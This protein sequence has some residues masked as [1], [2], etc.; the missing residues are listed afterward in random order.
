MFAAAAAVW[1]VA[2][3]EIPV[4]WN[5]SGEVD[6]YGGKF[7]GLLLLP[8]M[9]LG[10]YLLLR[11]LPRIDPLRANYARFSGV[12]TAIRVAVLLLMA[13]IYGVIIAW[14]LRKPIDMSRLMPAA[15]G[16]L[17]IF[18]G[19]V[20]GKVKP[21]WFVGIRTPWTLS[22][23]RSWERTHRLGGW[24]FIALGGLFLLAAILGLDGWGLGV[25]GAMIAVLV[26]LVVYSYFAWR[27]DPERQPPANSGPPERT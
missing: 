14:V 6:R 1:S 21:N 2:P 5:V 16:A 17:F 27:G 10:V 8:L 15:L 25:F 12:Y 9:A 26:F 3:S 22:S 19:S 24:L 4:H 13:A 18:L 23:R 11:Y 20:L 7:E